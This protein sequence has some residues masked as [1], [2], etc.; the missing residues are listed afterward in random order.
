MNQEAGVRVVA[1][2]N[3]IMADVA[4]EIEEDARNGILHARYSEGSLVVEIRAPVVGD[5]ILVESPGNPVRPLKVTL[6]EDGSVWLAPY[7]R[8]GR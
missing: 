8:E 1:R 7:V 5:V 3:A 2:A 6:A 4:R